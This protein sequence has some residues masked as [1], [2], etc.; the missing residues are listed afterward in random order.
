ME[1]NRRDVLKAVGVAAGGFTL[2]GCLGSSS[3]SD[4]T[5]NDA[6]DETVTPGDPG[7]FDI[8]S[9]I[10]EERM[11]QELEVTE[12]SLFR[13]ANN[14]GV[15][16][17]VANR[18]GAPL[19]SLTVH[20]ELVGTNNEVLGSYESSLPEAESIDDLATNE[21]WSGDVIFE[22]TKPDAFFNSVVAYRIWTTAEAEGSAPSDNSS[23]NGTTENATMQDGDVANNT[24]NKSMNSTTAANTGSM[25]TEKK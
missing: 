19:T 25:S 2:A 15:R 14:F 17:T 23:S 24:S 8:D 11:G 10:F 5:N 21:T 20:V 9:N 16:F 4:D 22:N 1:Q 7:W 6:G 12:S 13:T 3:G 18:R